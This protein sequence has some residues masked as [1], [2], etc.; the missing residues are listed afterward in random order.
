MAHAAGT[1]DEALS[2]V[3]AAHLA[4]CGHCRAAVHRAEML[5]GEILNTLEGSP[6]SDGCRS[7]TLGMIGTATLHRFPQKPRKG[8]SLPRPLRS[9]LADKELQ[10][11][12]WKKKAPGLA[13]YDLPVSKSSRGKLFLM[14]IGAGR[15]MPEHGHGGEELTL[16][17]SGAYN[18]SLGRFGVGDIA[19][20]DEEFEHQPVVEQGSECICLVATVK[21]ARFK[22]W[23]ARL[24]QPFIGI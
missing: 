13:L 14:K 12:A 21:P 11:V 7:K 4:M 23:P 24:L 3:V 2:F 19:D 1:L 16:I 6:V 9:L 20:L 18:D 17:L 10:D 22:S 8:S 5:G 15:A